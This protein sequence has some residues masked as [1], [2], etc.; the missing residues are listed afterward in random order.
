MYTTTYNKPVLSVE[1]CHYCGTV[2]LSPFFKHKCDCVAPHFLHYENVSVNLR[3]YVFGH[4][5]QK[6][7]GFPYCER[8]GI[9]IHSDQ[10]PASDIGK[11]LKKWINRFHYY[12]HRLFMRCPYC[13]EPE[14]ILCM[15]THDYADCLP[16]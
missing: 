1:Y 11:S 16:F 3:C 7:E 4:N 8:C 15:H 10:P 5:W 6:D 2:A 12:K 13:G 9:D 14:W